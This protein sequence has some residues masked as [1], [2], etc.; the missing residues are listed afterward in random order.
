M[1]SFPTEVAAPAGGKGVSAWLELVRAEFRETPGTRL[2]RQQIQRL[3]SLD[4]T[5]CDALVRALE[6]DG[7]LRVS[8]GAFVV[9]S[10]S[11]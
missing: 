9:A 1:I 11:V 8:K 6:T 4:G 10:P 7:F 3:W 2:T 5:T